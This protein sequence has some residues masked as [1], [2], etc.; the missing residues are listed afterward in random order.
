MFER[1]I[2]GQG[3]PDLWKVWV[4]SL[5]VD[6]KA[7]LRILVIAVRK[8]YSFCFI[9]WVYLGRGTKCGILGAL[10]NPCGVWGSEEI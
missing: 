7:I 10:N 4:F 2:D 6:G 9:E 1:N 8:K 5:L 3:L